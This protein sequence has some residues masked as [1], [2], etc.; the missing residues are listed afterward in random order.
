MIRPPRRTAGDRVLGDVEGDELPAAIDQTGELLVADVGDRQEGED[1]AEKQHLRLEDVPETGERLLTKDRLG[2][3]TR[4][5]LANPRGVLPPGSNAGGQQIRA[6]R[7][8][9]ARGARVRL[10]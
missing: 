4:R 5:R 3:V 7:L 2:D 9:C 1:P 10:G 6:E 8:K